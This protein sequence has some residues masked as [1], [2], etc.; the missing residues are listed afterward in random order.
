M[1]MTSFSGSLLAVV[2]LVTAIMVA[3]KIMS[4]PTDSSPE[5][6]TDSDVMEHKIRLSLIDIIDER[7]SHM[8]KNAYDR[9]ATEDQAEVVGCAMTS[10]VIHVAKQGLLTTGEQREYFSRTKF[11]PAIDQSLLSCRGMLMR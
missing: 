7:A 2:V 11:V 5:S 8:F 3:D 9:L 1:K 10:E 4:S 6:I